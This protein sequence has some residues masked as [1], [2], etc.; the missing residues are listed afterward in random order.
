[1]QGFNYCLF[2]DRDGTIN[3][4]KH[5]IK[6]PDELQLIPGAAQAIRE[7]REL[8]FKIIVV[9]NQSGVARGIMTEEDVKRVNNRLVELLSEEGAVVDAVYYCPHDASEGNGC[10]CRKPNAGMFE[11]AKQE[12]DIDFNRSIMVGDRLTDI[13]SGNR[14]GA[15]TVL[16]L[17]GYGARLQE[18]W[19]EKPGSIDIVAPTLYE[20]MPFMRAKVDEW[21][22]NKKGSEKAT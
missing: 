4:E 10:S 13:E 8:G 21:K 9:S 11:K 20:S 15:A 14:I 22:T 7:A 1:M 12:Y 19:T 18:S 3:F 2:L 6:D 5:F 16:V 17:T